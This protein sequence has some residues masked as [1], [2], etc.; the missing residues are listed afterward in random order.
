MRK[1]LGRLIDR[2]VAS[3]IARRERE[4]ALEALRRLGD[5]E[6]KDAGIYRHQIGDALTEIA[7]ERTRL[8]RGR[9]PG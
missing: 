7:R 2:W 5:R 4:A 3:V 8:Q 6:L 1:L 9:Q